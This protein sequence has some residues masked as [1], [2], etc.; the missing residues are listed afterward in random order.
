MKFLYS[1][2]PKPNWT[3]DK[4]LRKVC[5]LTYGLKVSFRLLKVLRK[6][7]Y[8]PISMLGF[9]EQMNSGP[10][11][12]VSNDLSPHNESRWYPV[13]GRGPTPHFVTHDLN[14]PVLSGQL[15]LVVWTGLLMDLLMLKEKFTVLPPQSAPD[16][17]QWQFHHP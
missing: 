1:N 17:S 12:L 8:W 15:Y 2:V 4:V 3:D 6:F 7:P 10:F 14:Y 16:C 5:D 9:L 11:F 13:V